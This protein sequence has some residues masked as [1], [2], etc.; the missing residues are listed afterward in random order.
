M[1]EN[2]FNFTTYFTEEEA[3]FLKEQHVVQRVR[4]KMAHEKKG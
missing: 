4:A 1:E 3:N 2:S